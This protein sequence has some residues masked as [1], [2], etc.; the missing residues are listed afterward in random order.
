[1]AYFQARINYN[2]SGRI[3]IA[4]GVGPQSKT[5][6]QHHPNNLPPSPDRQGGENSQRYSLLTSSATARVSPCLSVLVL[7]TPRGLSRVTTANAGVYLPP[8][9]PS[10][11]P[12][13]AGIHFWHCEGAQRGNLS[14]LLAV[15]VR[16]CSSS[17]PT[18]TFACHCER[19]AAISLPP[20]SACCLLP[21]AFFTPV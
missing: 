1:V 20:P 9:S 2:G 10:V 18:R 4:A 14:P 3:C 12:A 7:L 15:R 21:I 11:I 8:C 13:Q 17:Y 19:S 16:P 5:R 6:G